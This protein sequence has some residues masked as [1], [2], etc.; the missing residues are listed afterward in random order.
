MPP[1][2]TIKT[3]Y[4]ILMLIVIKIIYKI[5]YSLTAKQILSDINEASATANKGFKKYFLKSQDILVVFNI[6]ATVVLLPFVRGLE[7]LAYTI[8]PL[9]EEEKVHVDETF[10]SKWSC[11]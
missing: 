6:F 2:K 4:S 11:L 10:A 7:K 5:L 3:K 1:T 8:I 9:G